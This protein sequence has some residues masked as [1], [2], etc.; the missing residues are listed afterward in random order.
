[1][2]V[3]VSPTIQRRSRP[4]PP[5]NTAP[6]LFHTSPTDAFG[7]FRCYKNSLTQYNVSILSGGPTSEFLVEIPEPGTDT[8]TLKCSTSN[9]RR[10]QLT[11]SINIVP[12]NP[13]Y[14]MV[15]ILLAH[16]L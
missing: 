10:V 16:Y 13:H 8:S 15:Y 5:V 14:N 4:V 1:M 6:L 2:D 7:A 9:N 3:P 12:G 11:C